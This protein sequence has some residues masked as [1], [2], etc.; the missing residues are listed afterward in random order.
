MKIS[1]LSSVAVL[2]LAARGLWA[3]PVSLF[4][5]SQGTTVI[6]SSFVLCGAAINI[7]GGNTICGGDH[8]ATLIFQNSSPGAVDFVFFK[9]GAPITLSTIELFAHGD[10]GL[11]REFARFRFHLVDG[12][13]HIIQTLVDFTPPHPESPGNSLVI[14]SAFAPVAGQYFRAEWVQGNYPLTGPRIISLLG[15]GPRTISHIADGASFRTTF[16]LL[17]TSTTPANFILDFWSDT[18]APLMLDLGA[19]GITA[20]LSGV[21]PGGGTRFIRTAGTTVNLNKGWAQLSAPPAV[22]GNS[23]FG[24]QTPGQGDSDAA[25]PLSPS[26]GTDLFL[27]FDNTPGFAT[28]VAFAVPGQQAA[29]ISGSFLDDTGAPI[30]DASKVNVAKQGHDAEVMGGPTFFPATAGKRGAAH[31]S[32]GTNIFGLGIRANGK[33]FTT[34]EALSGVTA[35]TKVIAHIASGGGWKTTFLLVNTSA[36]AAQFTLD[37]FG[38]D[39]SAQPLPLDTGTTVSTL[40]G[41]IPAGGLHIVKATNTGAMT[42]SGWAQLT[43]TGPISGTAIFGLETAGQP[44]SE[45][46]VPFVIAG[47]KEL[48]MPFDYS[49]GYSTGIAFANPNPA[50]ATVTV[51]F[52]DETGNKLGS[53]QVQILAN[54]HASAVLVS[55]LASITGQ[56]G[57]VFLSSNVPILA[58]GIRAD[59]VAFTSLKVIVP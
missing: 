32:A 46:A 41:M 48:F 47:S 11:P 24:L 34:I 52:Y 25:V 31:F 20:S 7:F 33:A 37:F 57:L 43:V 21:I 2:C 23:V 10:G 58:L 22:D 19:D 42:T 54:G 4:D 51:K 5:I 45:A 53:G 39:G 14:A 49:A 18:G 44:D 9:T 26:G 13:N 38:N 16:I 15:F 17:N 6:A 28:G 50:V 55:L 59:G 56:R 30:A 29:T 27:P 36:A 3:A 35:A 1:A 8:S 40:T 12:T